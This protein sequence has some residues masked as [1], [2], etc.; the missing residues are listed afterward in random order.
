MLQ[1]NHRENERAKKKLNGSA[2]EKKKMENVI[3]FNL[4]YAGC[5][6]MYVE[7]A[8]FLDGMFYIFN[9]VMARMGL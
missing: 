7:C 1:Y 9:K 6:G 4:V 2:R 8:L 5:F 3:R